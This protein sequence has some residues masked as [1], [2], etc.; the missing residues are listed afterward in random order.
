MPSQ[1]LRQ[2][3]PITKKWAYF[4]HA[5]VGPLSLPAQQAIS[6]WAQQA[7]EAGDTVWHHWAARLEKI[8]NVAAGMIGADTDEIAFVSNTTAGIN[9]VAEGFPWSSGDNIVTLA[10]EFPSNLYPWMNLASQ[11]VQTRRVP[12]EQGRVDLNRIAEACD[13]QTRII[14]VSWVGYASGWRIDLDELVAMAHERGILVFL[15]AIQA[16]GVFPLDVKKTPVDFLAADGHKW[17]LSPEG[18]GLFYIRREHLD[19]LRPLGVGWNSV[20]Q[21]NDFS[22]IDLDL[23]PTAIRY[24]GGSQNMVGLHALGASLEML[25]QLGLTPHESPLA[26][27]LLQITDFACQRLEEIGARIVSH[28]DDRHSSGIVSFEIPGLDSSQQR[29]KSLPSGVVLNYRNGFLRIS[30]HAYTDEN[31]VERLI[32]SLTDH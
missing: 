22:Q 7:T 31:D 32:Q 8:R 13:E 15:D 6:N 17:L 1:A 16:L 21:G 12:V 25:T 19:R 5:A 18:A 20:Q 9:L 26:K 30:P 2:L 23:R 28:R 24:E 14:S 4:D 10:G 3:M 29:Q 27:Q 11:D